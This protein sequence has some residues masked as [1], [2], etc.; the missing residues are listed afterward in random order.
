MRYRIGLG[1]V[2]YPKKF[3]ISQFH[4]LPQHFEKSE[5][6][7][8]L[9]HH[10]QTAAHWIDA[11]L[12]VK[13]HQLLVHPR[14]IVLVLVPQL[15]HLWVKR[16]HLAHGPVRSVLNRPECELDNGGKSENGQAVIV[17]PTVEQV[18]EVQQKLADDFEY[19]EVH[20]LGFIVRKLREPMVKFRTGIDFEA[21]PVR[22][23]G[24]QLKCRHTKGALDG[25]Q[26]LL[27]RILDIETAPPHPSGLGGKW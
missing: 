24:L 23:P 13:L 11:V 2:F 14:W 15:L 16:G 19:S 8:D 17:Q 9:N 5:K 26:F 22:L 27:W 7:R 3:R 21:R 4:R 12:L 20:H 25:W 1:K 6:D 10:G 18:H